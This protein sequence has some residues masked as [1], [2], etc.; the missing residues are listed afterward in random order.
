MISPTSSGA[1]FQ[2]LDFERCYHGT[3]N[4]D[5]ERGEPSISAVNLTQKVALRVFT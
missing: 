1:P 4:A 3:V 5:Q 2:F